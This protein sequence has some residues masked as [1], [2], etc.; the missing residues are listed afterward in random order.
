MPLKH[1]METRLVVLL[2]G[3]LVG[4]GVLV[5]FLPPFPDGASLWG[6]IWVVTLLYPL[7]LWPLFHARRADYAFRMLHFLPSLLLFTWATLP[8]L[9][10]SGVPVSSLV[11]WYTWEGGLFPLLGS[12]LL[13]FLYCFRVIRQRVSRFIVL[14]GLLVLLVSPSVYGRWGVSVLLSLW[15]PFDSFRSMVVDEETPSVNT[16]PSSSLGEEVWRMRLRRMHRRQGRLGREDGLVDRPSLPP[17]G[18]PFLM[19]ASSSS[20]PPRLIS[21]GIG[22]ESSVF[23]LLALYTGILHARARR[24]VGPPLPMGEGE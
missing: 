4:T 8:M 23:F 3:A 18:V 20:I 5:R 1:A 10:L 16:D 11:E 12:F 6:G 2:G 21:S 24:R 19:S 13:L 22:L 17:E 7:L 15:G 9:R 14:F